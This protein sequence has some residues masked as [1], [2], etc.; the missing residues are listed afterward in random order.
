V[1]SEA[2]LYT[3]FVMNG[4]VFHDYSIFEIVNN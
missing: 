1:K 2:R 4:H 3:K